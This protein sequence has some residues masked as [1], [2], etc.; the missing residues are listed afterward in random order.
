M[1]S[2]CKF[3]HKMQVLPA[4]FDLLSHSLTMMAVDCGR[5][6]N[7]TDSI[8]N[9]NAA[10]RAAAGTQEELMVFAAVFSSIVVDAVV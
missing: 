1:H 6:Y 3:V 10:V 8:T 9:A 2:T 4:S 5:F 7:T